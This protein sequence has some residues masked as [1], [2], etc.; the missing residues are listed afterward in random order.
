[1][2]G[3][4]LALTLIA[5][6]D[7]AATQP[8]TAVS[9]RVID[10]ITGEPLADVRV[11][12]PD[13]HTTTDQEGRFAL[14]SSAR[15]TRLRFLANGYLDTNVAVD[16]AE[17]EVRLFP[18]TF[19]ETMDVVTG[20]PGFRDA[21][22]Q[23]SATPVSSQQV[24]QAAGAVDNVFRTLDTLPGVAPTDDFGSRLSVRG[25]APDQNLT[26]MDGVE[27]HNPYRLYGIASAFNPE[28]VENF[29]LRAGGFGVQYGDRLSSL[30]IIDNRTGGRTFR[31]TAAA[32]ITDGNVVIEGRTPGR[33]RGSWL[34]SARRTYYDLV[35]G[36]LQDQNFPSFADVQL[37]ADWEF[38]PG[39]RLSLLGL[40]SRE[41]A[42]L[43]I[44]GER[45]GERTMLGSE[46]RNDLVAAR[47]DAVLGSRGRSSTVVSTYRNSEFFDVNGTVRANAERSNAVDD[48]V[49]AGLA[50]VIFNRSVTI[51][52]LAVRQELSFQATPHHLLETG[53]ELHRLTTGL[54]LSITGDRNTSAA[55][56]SSVQGGAGLPDALDSSLAGTRGGLWIQDSF[57]PSARISLEPGLRLDWST[58]NG[59]NTLSPRFAASIATGRGI[60]L[61]T[62]VGLYTQ[63]PGYEKLLQSD[64]L[65]DLS[66]AREQR[67]RHERATHLVV[68]IEKAI[69]ADVNFRIEGYYKAFDDLIVGR[70]ETDT[71]RRTRL[72]A[73]DF[74]DTLHESVPTAP[75]ITSSPVNDAS[76]RAYGLDVYLARTDAAARLTG[77]MSYTWGR[78]ER[79]SYGRRS[80]FEYDR[81]HALNL[82]GRYG[83]TS[84]WILAATA[85]LASGFPY[86]PPIGLRVAAVENAQGRLVPRTDL[87]GNL[88]YS[89]D[90]GGVAHLNAGRLPHYA[91]IDLRVTYRRGGA[92]GRWSL[93]IEVLNLL[94]RNNAIALE[95]RLRH[96][97]NAEVPRL[98]E[99]PAQGFPRIPTIGFRFR[100]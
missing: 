46:A 90:Y 39:H 77:W 53:F 68:G 9:G 69:A 12:T 40:R 5:G 59:D 8:R 71:E 1:M 26:M 60:R 24:F 23:P 89:V 41:D 61:R 67:L 25:G 87:D 92:T 99:V 93:Y 18:N 74:P 86:T 72:A 31:G 85:R 73:Y 58:V 43:D 75:V 49:G 83:L 44:D 17:L 27:I 32:S 29:D 6:S 16:A 11:E 65:I 7:V 48:A 76:G 88:V 55:N 36:R 91:R 64:Y 15:I 51:D 84:R 19:T 42:D 52:D 56:G 54:R 3:G 38:G 94:D 81:R 62:A 10:G 30:L 21:P 80:M 70:L 45:P 96:D 79:H 100:F 22:E 34:L 13:A 33:A 66:S 20:L 4:L 2:L 63:S 28:T 95:T 97:P 37:Q 82:V 78:A 50:N 47:F 14:A 98:V 35:A 57:Q